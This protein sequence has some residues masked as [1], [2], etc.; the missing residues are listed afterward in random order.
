MLCFVFFN[1]REKAMNTM[2]DEVSIISRRAIFILNGCMIAIPFVVFMLWMGPELA[3]SKILVKVFGIF[4][5]SLHVISVN[6]LIVNPID[7]QL[8]F[9]VKSLLVLAKMIQLAPTLM[10]MFIL[11]LIFENYKNDV[12]FVVQNANY[13]RW[14]GFLLAIDTI[15]VK[16]IS[17]MLSSMVYAHSFTIITLET[18]FNDAE[19]KMFLAVFVL[20]ISQV[21]LKGSALQKENELTV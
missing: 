12:I 13:Y 10:I 18:C 21:M 1:E 3:I 5:L 15:F 14:I 11:K 7:P 16:P 9:S 4:K 2:I 19:G 17:V 20:L 8:S 6:G